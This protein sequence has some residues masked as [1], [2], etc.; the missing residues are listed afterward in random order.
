LKVVFF[1]I[2]CATAAL[3]SILYCTVQKEL[4]W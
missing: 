4:K 1:S 3:L 2:L